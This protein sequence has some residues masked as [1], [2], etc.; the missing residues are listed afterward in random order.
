MIT[1]LIAAVLYGNIGIKVLYAN[2]GREFFR[3]PALNTRS[4]RWI[5][6]FFVPI[7]WILA[8]IIAAAV[9]QVSYLGSFVGAA[10]ILQFSYTFPPLLQI[11]YN[12]LK[13]SLPADGGFDP[14]TGQ[15]TTDRGMQ[16][17]VRGFRVQLFRNLFETFYFLGA[18]VTGVLGIYASIVGMIDF[19]QSTAITA[20]TCLNPA[21]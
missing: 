4:G 16:R 8:F 3:F 1:G 9:P 7:Y 17:W 11:G 20:F 19:Y 15:V 10:F 5:W 6:I 12:C 13:D 18:A 21:G 14:A 2:V